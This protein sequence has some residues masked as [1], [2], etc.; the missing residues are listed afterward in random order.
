M[1]MKYIQEVEVLLDPVW[2]V[3]R[4]VD[5]NGGK[6]RKEPKITIKVIKLWHLT[7]Y[8]DANNQNTFR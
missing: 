5:L 1:Y 4:R 6:K 8:L 7:G 3:S 2:S